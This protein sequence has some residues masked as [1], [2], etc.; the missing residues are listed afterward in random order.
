MLDQNRRR[1][2]RA[3][4][5]TADALE[6]AAGQAEAGAWRWAAVATCMALQGALVAALSGYETALPAH[7]AHPDEAGKV[8]SISTLMRRAASPDFLA[9]P[10]RLSGHT[11]A[12]RQAL[13]LVELRNQIVHMPLD[14]RTVSEDAIAAALPGALALTRH[15][16]VDHPAF[17]DSDGAPYSSRIRA[18]LARFPV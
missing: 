18:A 5:T 4:E 3:L 13:E 10:E 2:R 17:L 9:D 7:V 12:K 6:F 1:V 11:G 16:A 15:L 14:G 8:A